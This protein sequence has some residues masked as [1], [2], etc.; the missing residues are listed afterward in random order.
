MVTGIANVI[1]ALGGIGL[2][3]FLVWI[4]SRGHDDRAAEEAARDHLLKHGRW[5]DDV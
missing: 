4:A 1:A 3:V 5:P 2:I